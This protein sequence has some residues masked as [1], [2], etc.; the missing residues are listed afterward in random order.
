M[1]SVA[2]IGQTRGKLLSD[3]YYERFAEIL[4]GNFRSRIEECWFHLWF[5]CAWAAMSCLK[6]CKTEVSRTTL[7]KWQLFSVL[8][9]YF[10]K[11]RMARIWT[12][13]FCPAHWKISETNFGH[14]GQNNSLF[15]QTSNDSGTLFPNK[16]FPTMMPTIISRAVAPVRS[17]FDCSSRVII[18]RN[19][20]LLL[21]H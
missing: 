14:F 20:T 19:K 16:V 11:F 18:Y 12:P 8:H 15:R 13:L 21:R 5:H 9:W 7:Y 2:F 17:I 4:A 3:N 6:Q 10:W 1:F